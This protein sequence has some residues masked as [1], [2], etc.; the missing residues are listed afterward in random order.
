MLCEIVLRAYNYIINL[1]T[2]KRKEDFENMRFYNSSYFNFIGIIPKLQRHL[3]IAA[4][5]DLIA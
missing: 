5:V 4:S 1:N 3:A 2:K